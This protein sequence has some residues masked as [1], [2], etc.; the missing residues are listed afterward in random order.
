MIE[1]LFHPGKQLELRAWAEKIMLAM[2]P[3]IVIAMMEGLAGYDHAASC[4]AA[5]VP[6]STVNGDLWPVAIERCRTVAPDFEVAV[7]TGAGHYPMLERP[8]ELNRHLAEI[9]TVMAS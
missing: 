5:G 3:K 6:I 9:A 8:E 4:R 2:D 7:M 1:M